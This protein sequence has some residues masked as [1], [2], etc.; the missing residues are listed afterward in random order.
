MPNLGSLSH[1]HGLEE[2]PAAMLLDLVLF[3]GRHIFWK[4]EQ[5][6]AFFQPRKNNIITIFSKIVISSEG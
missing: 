2:A 3:K 1:S 5:Q 6:Q 4:K